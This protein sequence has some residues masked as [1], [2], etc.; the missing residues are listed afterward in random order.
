[1]SITLYFAKLNLVSD[2]IFQ[3]YD[4][5]TQMNDVY[6][7]L[8][9][10]INSRQQLEKENYYTDE[11]GEIRKSVVEY[12]T[13]VLSIDKTY[14]YVEGWLY[15]KSMLYY[16]TLDA[17]TNTL[18]QQSTQNT[19][20]IRFVLDT[21]KEL[22]GY[23]TAIRFGYREFLDA[24]GKLI[25]L[26][27]EA[28]GY[29]Y[30]FSISLCSSGIDLDDIKLGLKSIGQIR[31]LKIRIQP[32]NPN[33]KL[34]EDIQKRADGYMKDM[35]DANV[36]ETEFVFSTRGSSGINLNSSLIDEKINDIQSLYSTLTLDESTRKGYVSVNATSTTGRVYASGES[37]PFKKV[38]DFIDEFFESCIDAFAQLR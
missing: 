31:D 5:P 22:V 25:N 4:N 23:D 6:N 24:F 21:K 34:L 26:G 9:D 35:K 13:H 1:M 30:R 2:D 19:E 8:Y 10:A 15:K 3:V 33:E 12:S 20:A 28:T 17:T 18:K 36:T 11:N 7:S 14:T 32:P 27:E 16:K 37:K 38:I 29:N